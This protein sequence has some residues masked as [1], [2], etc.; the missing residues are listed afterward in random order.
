MG[1]SLLY[2]AVSDE[3]MLEIWM[4]RGAETGFGALLQGELRAKELRG[5]KDVLFQHFSRLEFGG[6]IRS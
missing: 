6:R 3:Q 1:H 5:L 2:R 4:R